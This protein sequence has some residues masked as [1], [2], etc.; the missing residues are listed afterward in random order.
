MIS[1]VQ[2]AVR[3][4][5]S[6][7]PSDM[8]QCAN[9]A[10]LSDSSSR[11]TLYFIRS[12]SN[13]APGPDAVLTALVTN[14]Q[15]LSSQTN[16]KFSAASSNLVAPAFTTTTNT[17][18]ESDSGKTSVG[19]AVGVC[20]LGLGIGLLIA[21]GVAWYCLNNSSMNMKQPVFN[22][23]SSNGRHAMEMSRV[24]GETA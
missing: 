16:Q 15:A 10:T 20:F 23:P 1:A 4:T 21:F 9:I 22:E 7:V 11:V 12:S 18:Y 24:D 13:S 6:S 3:S 19:L 14:Q 2:E 5:H 17:V 8:I